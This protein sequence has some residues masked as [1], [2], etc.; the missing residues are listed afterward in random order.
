MAS[1][2]C[3]CCGG[4]GLQPTHKQIQDYAVRKYNRDYPRPVTVADAMRR[5]KCDASK[6][7]KVVG[8]L[9]DD[10]SGPYFFIVGAP[11]MPADKLIFDFD[12]E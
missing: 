10:S 6:I 8:F 3:V 12:G 2:D 1:M 9:H 7:F 4:D 11:D 5:F